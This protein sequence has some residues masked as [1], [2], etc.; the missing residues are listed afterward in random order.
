MK[1]VRLGDVADVMI[2]GIDKKTKEGEK[3]VK[4]C[5]FVDVYY[6]WAITKNM[7]DGLMLA[8]ASD[9]DI[10]LFSLRKGQVAI[11]KDSETRDDIG[12]AA[13]IA[14]DFENVVLGYHCALITPKD[15]IP[16]EDRLCG[17]YLNAILHTR[18]AQKHFSNNATGSGQR[19]TLS[20]E[21]VEDT[22]LYLPSFEEQKLIGNYLSDI[23]HK[24]ELN[25]LINDKLET[26]IKQIYDYWF[27]QFDF[28]NKEGKP[29]KSSGGK[30]VWNETLKREIPDGWN[31]D[32]VASIA[33]I[34]SGGT[35]SKAEKT[36]WNGTIPFFGPTDYTGNMYQI[37]TA[38]YITE[39]GLKHCASHLYEEGTI[40]ITARG[41]IGKLVIVGK[42]M[43][44][45]QSCYAL[46]EKEG[47]FEYL[48]FLT[49]Q[50]IDILKIKGNGSVFKS[51][52]ASDI[53]TSFLCIGG[54]D[55]I[56]YF[57]SVTKEIFDKILN[58]TKEIEELQYLRT[59]L[60]P[61][62]MNGQVTIKD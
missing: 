8:S 56:E 13:Y 33:D 37:N 54:K 43:A 46:K 36:Y 29:Y 62:L 12:V 9:N 27:V 4:L 39:E 22:I 34:L 32:S 10:E 28:P 31:A 23:D 51:I 60:L 19:Y 52:I 14:D 7:Y 55:I 38:E 5:N 48:Y 6:N 1:R 16:E 30:M 58:N 20:K 61:L 57:S 11:T 2:S 59:Y 42:P 3:A 24:I 21:S 47:H 26:I 40:F 15:D 53:E 25:N 41:S 17:K 35:P 45:N 18:Y 44:M 50:L 49:K